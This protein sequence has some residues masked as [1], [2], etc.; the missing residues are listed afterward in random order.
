[1]IKIMVL[2]IPNVGKSSLINSLRRKF[3]GIGN[4]STV[5]ID[6]RARQKFRSFNSSNSNRKGVTEVIREFEPTICCNMPVIAG[7]LCLGIMLG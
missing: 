6:P 1:M 5:T 2:G 3:L 7:V 4:L